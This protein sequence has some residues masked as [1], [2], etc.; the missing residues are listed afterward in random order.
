MLPLP[1]CAFCDRQLPPHC[2]YCYDCNNTFT[3]EF[4]EGWTKTD[5]ATYKMRSQ[6]EERRRNATQEKLCRIDIE[7]AREMVKKTE[8]ARQIVEICH[9]N[10]LG[11]L[12]TSRYLQ[13]LGMPHGKGFIESHHRRVKNG[14]TLLR[15]PPSAALCDLLKRSKTRKPKPRA[16]QEKQML[17]LEA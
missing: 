15:H 3:R 10:G 9:A 8:V 1:T 13:N 17:E 16:L 4:G 5:W 11:W 6:H 14:M 7:A 12:R 2:V